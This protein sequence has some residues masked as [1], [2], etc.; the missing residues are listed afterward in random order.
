[1]I[2]IRTEKPYEIK[3]E[4]DIPA[5]AERGKF[6]SPSATRS[7]PIYLDDDVLKY[8]SELAWSRGMETRELLNEMLR[9]QMPATRTATSPAKGPGDGS[10]YAT[11]GELAERR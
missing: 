5:D 8:F 4:Y 1:M 2:Q 9:R 3:E 6:Y 7:W 11:P 10:D